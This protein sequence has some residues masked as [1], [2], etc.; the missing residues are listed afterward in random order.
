MTKNTLESGKIK[1]SIIK[2]LIQ[3]KL[4]EDKNLNFTEV[5]K[6]ISFNI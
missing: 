4:K 6:S 1:T 5:M 2:I 3:N